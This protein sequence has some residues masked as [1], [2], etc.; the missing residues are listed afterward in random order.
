MAMD[1]T[2]DQKGYYVG[3]DDGAP[4]GCRAGNAGFVGRSRAQAQKRSA[5]LVQ[6]E[7]AFGISWNLV[8]AGDGSGRGTSIKF[9]YLLIVV[10]T[11]SSAV[12]QC[13]MSRDLTDVMF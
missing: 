11:H 8:S 6:Q 2:K 13:N 9:R 5:V 7:Y 12:I 1:I 3:A 4:V 10:N